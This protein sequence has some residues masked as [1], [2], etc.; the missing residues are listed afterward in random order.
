MG[1]PTTCIINT[2]KAQFSSPFLLFAKY[3]LKSA[4]PGELFTFALFHFH[5]A[6]SSSLCIYSNGGKVNRKECTTCFR[7]SW[8]TAIFFILIELWLQNNDALTLLPPFHPKLTKSDK[9][10]K[11]LEHGSIQKGLLPK[12]NQR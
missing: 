3:F 5:G 8:S 6:A 7:Q 9:K 11:L 2:Q 10:W 1:K 4:N 12:C